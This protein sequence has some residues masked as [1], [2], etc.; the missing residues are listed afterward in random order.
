MTD[1]KQQEIT[2]DTHGKLQDLKGV[3][4]KLH[5]LLDE[6]QTHEKVIVKMDGLL[7]SSPTS[8]ELIEFAKEEREAAQREYDVCIYV[9]N[10]HLGRITRDFPTIGS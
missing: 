5:D 2:K 1:V 9:A 7:E 6:A 3:V 10:C 8:L 4:S